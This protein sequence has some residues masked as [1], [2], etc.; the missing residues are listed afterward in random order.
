MKYDD[1]PSLHPLQGS[2]A[3]GNAKRTSDSYTEQIQILNQSSMNGY[4][5]SLIH[6]SE[7]TR[8]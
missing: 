1:N 6:I 2:C 3:P 8:P 4:N 5:L 7:P